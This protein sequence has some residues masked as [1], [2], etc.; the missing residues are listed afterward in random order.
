MTGDTSK[1]FQ[2]G[3]TL[4]SSVWKLLGTFL[5]RKICCATSSVQEP[6]VS[7]Y[8][9]RFLVRLNVAKVTNHQFLSGWARE[10]A[11]QSASSYLSDFCLVGLGIWTENLVSFMRNVCAWGKTSGA[12][13]SNTKNSKNLNAVCLWVKC[14][15]VSSNPVCPLLWI[16]TFECLLSQS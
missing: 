3:H 10:W 7:L 9:E 16:F 13:I 6:F 12:F 5:L 14:R 1:R 2:T 4:R 8:A 15:W 11:K